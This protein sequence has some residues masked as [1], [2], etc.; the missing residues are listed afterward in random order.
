[1]EAWG[2]KMK[3]GKRKAGGG[4]MRETEWGTEKTKKVV[5]SG[6]RGVEPLSS[7]S[8]ASSTSPRRRG[9]SR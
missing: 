5:E 2:V 4:G 9:K 3:W 6:Q 1:M 8:V 7:M